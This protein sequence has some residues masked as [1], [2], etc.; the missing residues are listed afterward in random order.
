MTA[1]LE[2]AHAFARDRGVTRPL[3]ALVRVLLTPFLR[4]WFRL[5]VSG[6]EHVPAEGAAIVVAN[7]KSF[8]DT[9]FLA[10]GTRRHLR[11]MAKAELFR[12][13][14]GWLLPRLGA[15]PVR[16]GQADSDAMETAAAI[17]GHGGLVAIFP[18]GTRVDEPDALGAPRHG[19]GHLALATGA[20]IVPAAVSGTAHLWLGPLPKPRRVRVTFLEPVEASALAGSPD[21]VH[22]LVDDEVWPAVRSEYGRLS[23][24][25]G[26][27]FAGLAAAGL[28]ARRQTREPRLI[29]RLEPGRVRKRRRRRARMRRI[30]GVLPGGR[31]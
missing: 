9:F 10:I 30:R 7:H 2:R 3:Y 20:P 26:A 22:V 21:A 15:F 1:E 13:P 23:A 16:R 28:V 24:A 25:G 12:G 5:R 27:L 17:L 8:L 29:G 11:Y 6:A 14:A 4:I 18:E 31:R 19:A